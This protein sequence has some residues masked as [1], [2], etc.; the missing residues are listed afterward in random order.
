MKY[1][2]ALSDLKREI[3]QK[4]SV[5]DVL[6]ADLWAALADFVALTSLE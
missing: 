6:K 4:S 2:W 3:F 5:W 1:S